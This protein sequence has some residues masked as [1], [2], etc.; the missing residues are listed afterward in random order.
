[1]NRDRQQDDNDDDELPDTTCEGFGPPS[2]IA[3]DDQ[4]S[5]VN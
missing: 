4:E 2:E 3:D 1:M 5:E